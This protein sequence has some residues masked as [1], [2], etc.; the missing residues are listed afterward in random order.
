LLGV[1]VHCASSSPLCSGSNGA[2]DLL[3]D[4][5]GGYTNF[6]ALYGNINVAPVICQNASAAACD[7]NGHVKDIN[8]NLVTDAFGRPGF[9]SGFS[10]TAAQSLGY[11]AAMLERGISVVYL[12]IADAHDR[13]P[14]TPDPT[15]GFTTARAFGPGE[16]EYVAQLRAYDQAFGAFFARLAARGITRENTLF[17]VVPDENDHFVG[18]QPTPVGCDGINVPCTY[19]FASEINASLNRLLA[20]QRGNTTPQVVH[21][22]DAPNM[23]IVGNPAPTAPVTRTM[24][25]D[26][27]ALTTTNP[28]TGKTDK[29]SLFLADQAEMKLL[30]MVTASPARTP[31]LT[32]FGNDDYFFS[33][34]SKNAAV[35]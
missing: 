19:Q 5:P 4:E 31:T 14:L 25:Y 30:H 24:E 23:Y 13:N 3:P 16:A 28:I 35:P 32:M 21:N 27:D 18:S 15:T 7:S 22:D 6:N 1:A 10:P 20:T 9:P 17:V 34:D 8:G 12:Y 33:N 29:L 2:P 26:L 11:A